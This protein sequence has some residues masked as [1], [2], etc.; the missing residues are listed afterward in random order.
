MKKLLGIVVLGLLVC[1]N[2]FADYHFNLPKDVA[3]GNKYFKSLEKDFKKHGVQIVNKKDGHPVRAGKKSIRFEVR[4][5]DCG[6]DDSWSD[7]KKDRERHELS[8]KRFGPGEWW[9]AWSIFIPEDFPIIFPTK[10]MFGQFYLKGEGPIFAFENQWPDRNI[11]GGYHV[12]R[13]FIHYNKLDTIASDEEMR[14]KWTDILVHAKWS[15]KDD[16]FFKVWVNSQPKYD[17]KGRTLLKKSSKV[18]FKFGIYRSFMTRWRNKNNLQDVPA[19]VLYFDEV[20]IGKT[21]EKV[22]GK[23]PPRQ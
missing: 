6:Y 19:Q 15:D 18:Y 12:E 4:P 11:G 14:G 10:A 1:S 8:G 2:S 22:V 7:C 17:Y 21:K 5:G 9:H 23:L 20:R 3:S 13:D 16:G